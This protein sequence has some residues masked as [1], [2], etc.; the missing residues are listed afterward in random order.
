MSESWGANGAGGRLSGAEAAELSQQIA[1]LTKANLPLGAGL[2]A[3]GEELPRGRLRASMDELAEKL[4]TGVALDEALELQKDRIP[5]HLRGLVIAGT[6]SGELGGILGRFSRYV[7]VGTELKRR[8]WLNLAYPTLTLAISIGLF[9]FIASVVVPQ[10]E[11]IFRDFVIPLPFLTLT[12]ITMSR[13]ATK[14]LVPFLIVVLGLFFAW[15]FGR[16]VLST[17]LRRSVASRLPIVGGVWRTTA[18]AEF[19]HL[20]AL[21]LESRL[22]LPEALRLTGEGVQDADVDAACRL[23]ATDVE[24]GQSLAQAMAQRRRFPSGLSRLLRWAEKE[25]SLEEVLHIAGTMYEARARSQ[26]S[27][28]GAVFNVLCVFLVMGMMTIVPLLFI[29]LITLIARLSG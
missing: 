16:L 19:C 22:P 24:S 26:A 8:L 25:M 10:F 1:G 7:N 29:P 18:L 17:S 15:L 6:R 11:S 28:V 14:L 2:H 21:L 12:V 23:M 13:V 5:P 4:E 27:F 20:L 3:L 9:L